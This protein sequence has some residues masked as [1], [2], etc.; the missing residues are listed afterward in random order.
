MVISKLASQVSFSY[1]NTGIAAGHVYYFLEDVFP[2]Q[3]G[4]FRILKTPRFLYVLDVPFSFVQ[5][6]YM[7]S[8]VRKTI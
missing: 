8:L 4:G 7:F 2:Q 5:I 3:P 6:S 1:H